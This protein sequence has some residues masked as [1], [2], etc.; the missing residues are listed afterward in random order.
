MKKTVLVAALLAATVTHASAQPVP[1]GTSALGDAYVGVSAGALFANDTD[2]S[3]SGSL[4]GVPVSGA[5]KLR[6]KPGFMIDL[7]VGYN[8]N[9]YLAVEGDVGYARYSYDK[10]EGQ[11]TAGTLSVNGSQFD[12][13]VSNWLGFMN[14][15][16]TPLGRSTF[17]PYLGAGVGFSAYEATV[18]A[19]S[20]NGLGRITVDSK[21]TNTDFAANALAGFDYAVTD[22]VSIGARYR[23]IWTDSATSS[24]TGDLTI[25]ADNARHHVVSATTT[26]RF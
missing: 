16:V 11:L 14:A 19:I 10:V 7:R 1:A 15:I 25:A 23:F 20:V 3:I 9:P 5:G 13:H 21:T 4:S 8:I 2:Q 26:Y 12:G 24:K 18:N 6:F 22:S 17:T